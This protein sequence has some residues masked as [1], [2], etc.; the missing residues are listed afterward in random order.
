[1]D[2]TEKKFVPYHVMLELSD[3]CLLL[4][5]HTSS[6]RSCFYCSNNL[7]FHRRFHYRS[8]N[9]LLVVENYI[10]YIVPIEEDTLVFYKSDK[11]ERW[12]IEIPFIS[13][14]NNKLKGI[15]YYHVLI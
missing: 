13:N 6:G 4:F 15:R 8:N 3:R 10:K 5:N 1:M 7:V 9:I 14:V 11:T 12:W 2:L